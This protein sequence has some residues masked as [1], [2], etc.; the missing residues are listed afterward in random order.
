[1]Y[2]HI[3]ERKEIPNDVKLLTLHFCYAEAYR[4]HWHCTFAMPKH[5]DV[6]SWLAGNSGEMVIYAFLLGF[7]SLS[8]QKEWY[9]C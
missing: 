6:I 2:G 7:S 5:T 4:C 1:M 9:E 8:R 3:R